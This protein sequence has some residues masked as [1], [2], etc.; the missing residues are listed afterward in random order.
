MD[1]LYHFIK[2][3]EALETRENV[4]VMTLVSREPRQIV[5]FS[6]CLLRKHGFAARLLA[7]T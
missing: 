5:G 7:G 2:Y 1:E 4:Y 6:V 3:K